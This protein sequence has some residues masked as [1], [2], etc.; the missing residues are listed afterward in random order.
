MKKKQIFNLIMVLAVVLIIGAGIVTAG[1]I[2][3]WFDG[4]TEDGARLADLRGIVTLERNG[5]ACN[6]SAD[7][8]LREGDRIETA[9]GAEA[10][11]QVGDSRIIMGEKSELTVGCPAKEEFSAAVGKGEIFTRG[12]TPLE[13]SFEKG[14]VQISEAVTS[15]SVRTGA[16]SI[17]V[18]EGSVP[19]KDQTIEAGSV[20]SLTADEEQM[21]SCQ[22][23][24][25][26]DFLLRQL[27]NVPEDIRM[28]FTAQ[29]LDRIVRERQEA[30]A[31]RP[32]SE[33]EMTEEPVK[34]SESAEETQ[35]TA[36]TETTEKTE[37][38]PVKQTEEA[39][40]TEEAARTE[41]PTEET[42]TSEPTE[43]PTTEEPATE[44][45]GN[46]C[47]LTIRCDTILSNMDHL[48]PGKVEFVP[49]NG[50]I[51]WGAS[52][53]FEDGET[54]FDV[55]KRACEKYGIQLEYSWTPMYNSYYV[56]GINYLYEFDCGSESGWM[57]KVNGWF[58]N[59]GCSEYTLKDGDRIEFCYTCN[60]LGADV[61]GGVW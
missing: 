13:L 47:T 19:W 34:T 30:L 46:T 48:D 24:M 45:K 54:A 16:W 23:S 36:V 61:G 60:G 58:P 25:L 55:L 10:E 51:L 22:E 50:Y 2:L 9:F 38:K 42:E 27:R 21:V 29:D 15:L 26:N 12:D 49:E 56:E 35:E 7:T 40:S 1:S 53:K 8:A 5:I 39:A 33:P 4:D 31:Q 28:C 59:Y 11:L 37:Q 17:S 32:S 3:G 41:E 57:Y 20:L 6:A 14:T 52:V 44:E 43:V 18:Y